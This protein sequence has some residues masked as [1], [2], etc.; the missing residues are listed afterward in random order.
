[1]FEVI[2]A[3][4][5]TTNRWLFIINTQNMYQC[6]MLWCYL[7]IKIHSLS[8]VLFVSLELLKWI[9][10]CSRVRLMDRQAN[11]ILY[12]CTTHSVILCKHFSSAASYCRRNKQQLRSITNTIAIECK[13]VH[14]SEKLRIDH[15]TQTKP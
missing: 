12:T 7:N 2:K 11:Q 3:R 13:F 8:T 10:C 15:K 9:K 1:M 6:N 5:A 4:T 14:A